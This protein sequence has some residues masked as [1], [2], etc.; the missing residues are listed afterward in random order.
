MYCMYRV[1]EQYPCEYEWNFCQI[2]GLIAARGIGF[3]LQ[4]NTE[5]QLSRGRGGVEERIVGA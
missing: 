4:S 5:Q 3:I 2:L 1:G